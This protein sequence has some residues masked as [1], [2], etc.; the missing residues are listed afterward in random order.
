MFAGFAFFLLLIS[1]LFAISDH[2]PTHAYAQE[3]S[4]GDL[5]HFILRTGFGISRSERNDLQSLSRS[6]AVDHLVN[7]ARKTSF[8]SFPEWIRE[9]AEIERPPKNM[10]REDRKEFQKARRK[11]GLEL[12]AWWFREMVQT[13]TPFTERMTLFW[14]NHFTSSLQKVKFPLLIALQNQ[15]L[16]KH[17]V[18]NFRDLLSAI[19]RDPAMTIYLDGQSNLKANPNENFARELLELFTLGEGNY[20]EDDIKEAARAFTGHRVNRKSAEYV[21]NY[22]QHDHGMKDFLGQR[23]RFM[24]EDIVS[25]LLE[26]PQTATLITRKLWKEF[27]ST[28]IPASRLRELSTGFRLSN[29]SI[30]DL[31]SWILKAPEFWSPGNRGTSIKSPVELIVGTIRSLGI[32]AIDYIQLTRLSKRLGQDI[33][34]PPSVKGWDGGKN[35]IN[36]H[37]LLL[38]YLALTRLAKSLEK[39]DSPPPSGDLLWMAAPPVLE[40][41]SAPKKKLLVKLLDPAWQLK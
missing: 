15:L 39:S 29:Y 7:S 19:S 5:R 23:G 13:D 20:S 41:K 38:R 12:K 21:V 31:L 3:L 10:A 36:S 6:Q 26:N 32:R 18:G 22:R 2:S 27:I 4:H 40:M 24:G 14:H 17:A 9:G 1:P 33:L 8:T 35:W 37:T 34:D 28:P 16:R 11:R 30:P 25:I